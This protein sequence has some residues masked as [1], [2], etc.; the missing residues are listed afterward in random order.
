MNW[1]EILGLILGSSAVATLLNGLVMRSKTKAETDGTV[2]EHYDAYADRLEH[3]I[4]V[5]EKRVHVVEERNSILSGA[6]SCAYRC[7]HVDI[8]PVLDQMGKDGNQAGQE[9]SE[10]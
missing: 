3:R 5:L 9:V 4:S 8:C 10:V 7:D 1:A 6:I 2:S